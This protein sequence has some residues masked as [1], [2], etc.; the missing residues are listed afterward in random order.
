MLLAVARIFGGGPMHPQTKL[1]DLQQARQLA[2]QAR[3]VALPA[4]ARA[5]VEAMAATIDALAAEVEQ[6]RSAAPSS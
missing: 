2:E 5:L 6:L 4:N 3:D 1:T